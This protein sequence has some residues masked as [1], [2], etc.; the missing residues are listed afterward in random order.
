MTMTMTM[1]M[2]NTVFRHKLYNRYNY[3]RERK[4][5]VNDMETIQI[6]IIC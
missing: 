5:A 6:Y 1:T 3:I 2:K 4:E